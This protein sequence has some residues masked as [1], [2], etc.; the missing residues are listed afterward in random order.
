MDYF[1]SLVPDHDS[2]DSFGVNNALYWYAA[3]ISALI[4]INNWKE[5]GGALLVH[6]LAWLNSGKGPSV[7]Y[8]FLTGIRLHRGEW[9]PS[10]VPLVVD[11][12][13]LQMGVR[14]NVAHG[15][16]LLLGFAASYFNIV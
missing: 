14:T 6:V 3:T 11:I 13:D 5:I 15:F 8:N 16:A 12:K 2:T 4:G 1:K 9:K 7:V 10:I